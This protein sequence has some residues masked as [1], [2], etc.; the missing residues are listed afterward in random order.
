ME[1]KVTALG[2]KKLGVTCIRGT[3][4]VWR[5]PDTVNVSATGGI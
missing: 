3:L 5:C 2:E 1:R 4:K